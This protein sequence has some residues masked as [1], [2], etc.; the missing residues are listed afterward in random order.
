MDKR[1]VKM[2]A[3]RKIML[4]YADALCEAAG[5]LCV[6]SFEQNQVVQK[7]TWM[8]VPNVKIHDIGDVNSEQ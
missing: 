3:F 7:H 6:Q 8:N 1:N 5:K 2:D 4:S